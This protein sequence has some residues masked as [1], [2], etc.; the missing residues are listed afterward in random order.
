M[1]PTIF[2][3]VCSLL[4]CTLLIVIIFSRKN[5]KDR[6]N[7]ILKILIITNLFGLLL[8][9]AGLFLSSNYES[10]ELL[11]DIVL[12]V[13]LVYYLLWMSLF[14][15]YIFIISGIDSKKIKKYILVLG[16]IFLAAVIYDLCVPLYYNVND[17]VIMYSSGPAVNF[18]YNYTFG[19]S[20]VCLFIMFKNFKKNIAV[21]YAPLFVFISLGGLIS[22]IQSYNPELLLSTSMQTFITYL[23]YFTTSR[24]QINGPLSKKVNK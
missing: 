21:K 12:R 4:Y 14:V 16:I 19:C 13:M 24:S 15:V 1:N 8:E 20:F 5:K 2:F 22:I 3:S 10:Y 18:V 7:N 11:N 9:V 17:G 23:I 6:E